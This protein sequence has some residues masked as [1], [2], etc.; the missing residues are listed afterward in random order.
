MKQSKKA[1]TKAT[2]VKIRDLKP[3][4]DARAGAKALPSPEPNPPAPP[5]PFVPIPYPNLGR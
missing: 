3:K 4:K 1:N 2:S 5:G